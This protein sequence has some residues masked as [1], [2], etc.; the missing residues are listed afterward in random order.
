MT[1]LGAL[2]QHLLQAMLADAPSRLRE[3]RG[4]DAA[5]IASRL[6][7]YRN[8]YR[9]RLR[10]A[11]TVEYPGL[12]LMAGRRMAHLLESYVEAHPSEHYNI[13]WYGAGLAAHLECALPWR[14]QPE[15]ADMARLD[16]AISTVFDAADEPA[17]STADLS[18]LP[19]DSWADLCL[20]PQDALQILTSAF[21]VD[22]FRRMADRGRP[23]PRLRRLG[24]PRHMLVWRQVL[25]V[26]YRV[27]DADE[28]SAL[29]GA[30]RGETFARLCERLGEY[31][32]PAMALPRMAAL[33]SQWLDDGLIRGLRS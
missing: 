22:A 21:N 27:I 6:A 28:L 15:L 30:L 17:F 33:L 18:G 3:L 9:V 8:G 32:D 16:W 13:R 20:H 23:R 10:D 24:K 26:R 12:G 4:D 5:D 11:L 29:S 31:H 1:H 25:E 14:E 7:V 2:Q 19:A